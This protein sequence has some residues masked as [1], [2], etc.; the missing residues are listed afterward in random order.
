MSCLESTARA[1]QRT[2]ALAPLLRAAI[3]VSVIRCLFL[4][5]LNINLGVSELLCYQAERLLE[6]HL[7]DSTDCCAF[8][9]VAHP[10]HTI[11]QSHS[12]TR[13]EVSLQPGRLA[14]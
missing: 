5:A 10:S 14:Q 4:R 2:G 9:N 6:I 3:L 12:N 13:V 8:S 1:F 7:P 11:S